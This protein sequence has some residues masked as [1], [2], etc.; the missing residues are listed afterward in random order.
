MG[1]RRQHL[2]D[3][4]EGVGDQRG[5]VCGDLDLRAFHAPAHDAGIEA[6]DDPPPQ[7]LEGPLEAHVFTRRP[8]PEAHDE[9]PAVGP[10]AGQQRQPLRGAL[11]GVALR[12][13]LHARLR[14]RRDRRLRAERGHCRWQGHRGGQQQ[15]R[16]A[17]LRELR[18]EE[19]RRRLRRAPGQRV[20]AAARRVAAR[21]HR[22]GRHRD[23]PGDARLGPGEARQN[24]QLHQPGGGGGLRAH[25]PAR[26]HTDL[27]AVRRAGGAVRAP[28][29]EVAHRPARRR[30]HGGGA[31]GL[32]DRHGLQLPVGGGG[33]HDVQHHPQGVEGRHGEHAGQVR[34]P[35][36]FPGRGLPGPAPHGEQRERAPPLPRLRRGGRQGAGAPGDGAQVRLQRHHLGG[37]GQLAGHDHRL[38][39]EQHGAA[40]LHAGGE[41]P[42]HHPAF[43]LDPG[44]VG[45]AQRLGGAHQEGAALEPLPPRRAR[46]LRRHLGHVPRGEDGADRGPA[47]AKAGGHAGP[48]RLPGAPRHHRPPQRCERDAREGDHR[49]GVRRREV[50]PA[51]Q[52][53]LEV[54]RVDADRRLDLRLVRCAVRGRRRGARPRRCSHPAHRARKS[55]AP[56]VSC[57]DQR[58]DRPVAKQG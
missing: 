10:V 48:R 3:L 41:P 45:A 15:D 29:R 53:Q 28:G 1:L 50:L 56:Q 26:D 16:R 47:R 13:Q 52:A 31:G 20:P 11:R 9:D 19:P 7:P 32:D 55:H 23:P 34:G 58:A 39:E 12:R 4:Q 51:V 43:L 38:D 6:A 14:L 57:T 42:A 5:G 54:R 40:L 35:G 2:D 49:V 46:P 27:R 8:V 37:R 30:H 33:H 36:D 17:L 22:R 24:L 18:G 21:D 25:R 44:D